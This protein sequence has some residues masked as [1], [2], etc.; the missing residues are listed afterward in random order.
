MNCNLHK[1][2]VINYDHLE[3]V[4]LDVLNKYAPGSKI[5][6]KKFT[7][8]KVFVKPS[9]IDLREREVHERKINS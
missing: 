4:Y 2:P 5:K 7:W 1:Q 3:K 8:P 9:W 6:L